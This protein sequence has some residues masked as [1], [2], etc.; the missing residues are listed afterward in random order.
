MTK[1][2]VNGELVDLT[3]EEQTEFDNQPVD[4]EE[5]QLQRKIN[6]QV[7]L[8]REQLLKDSDWSQLS[9]NGLSSEKKTEWQTYRQELRD[10][11]STISSKEDI[12]DLAYPTKPE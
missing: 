12:A 8:P 1:K 3:A 9:D 2:I 7:R 5:K 6:E 10:L 4:T 11:P